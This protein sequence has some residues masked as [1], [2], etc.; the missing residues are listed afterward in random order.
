VEG[1]RPFVAL[2]VLLEFYTTRA[3]YFH[4]VNGGFD[5]VDSGLG[6]HDLSIT[7]NNL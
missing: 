3:D 7:E 1:T 6:E 2:A 5:T 4:G